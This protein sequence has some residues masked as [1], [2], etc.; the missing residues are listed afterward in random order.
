MTKDIMLFVLFLA[1]LLLCA[2]P[3][4][5]YMARVF[6][7][8][9]TC[10]ERFFAPLENIFYKMAKVD[11]RTEMPW[12]EYCLNLIIFNALGML[13]LFVLQLTQAF[14]PLNPQQLPNVETWHLAF[15]TAASFMT[16]TNWQA[17]SGET[18]LSYLTQMLGLT[19][20]NFLSAATGAAVAIALIRGLVRKNTGELGNFWADII[21]CTTRILLPI[22]VVA[23][24]LLV[25]QGV[26]QNLNP[27]V[28]VQTVEGAQ[29][30]IAMGP[31][32]S[33]EAIKELGTNGGGFFN[34]NSSHPFENPTPWS[35][36][37]EMFLILVIPTGL[38]FTFGEMCKDKKTRL[39]CFGI[40]AASF[41]FDVGSLLCF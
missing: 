10:G 41:C 36:F 37:L 1:V 39:C 35:N 34:A 2:W 25:S 5:K 22:C 20:Q 9:K 21:R 30:T 15:N 32:A 24:L 27:Y 14:L 40:H 38:L 28:D 16:N 8:E 19:V 17:Y 23:T 31:V 7:Y 11:P 12:K 6:N 18:T 33:Q 4:G 3:L 26:I 13:S 29:Q